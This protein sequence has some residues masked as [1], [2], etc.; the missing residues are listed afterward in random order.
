MSTATV[1]TDTIPRHGRTRLLPRP[2]LEAAGFLTLLLGAWAG[3][4][5]YVGPSFG[6]SA[7]GTSAW[8]WNF[9]HGMLFLL[10]GA[11]AFLAGALTMMGAATDRRAILGFAGILAAVCGAWLVVG[12]VA[13]PVLGHAAFFRT[14]P[15]GTRDLAY[16]IGY[17]LG[18]GGLLIAL[19][20]FILGRDRYLITPSVAA[21]DRFEA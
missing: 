14:I 19:G 1:P 6:F 9:T 17:S 3:I 4:V 16:W 15:S 7:D 13:W 11:G 2:S 8:T 20:A 18:P 21:V 12:P 5:A 10:P